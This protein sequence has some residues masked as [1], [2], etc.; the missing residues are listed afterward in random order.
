[1]STASLDDLQELERRYA[2]G[3]YARNP[4]QFVRGSGCR[5]WDSDGH[6]YLDFLAGISVLNVGH[7]HP[8]VVSA[9][10]EQAGRLTHATNLYYTAPALELSARLAESSL[11]GKVFLCNSGAEAN[12]A[13]IKLARRARPQGKLI[14]LEEAFHGRTYGALSATPQESKQAPFAPLVPGFE[15]VPKQATALAAAVDDQTAA[16]LLEPIQGETGIHVLSHEL[17]Q[18]ARAACDA[19]GAALIF[20]EIQTGMGRTGTLWAYEQCGVVPDALTSAKALGGGLPAGAL[21]TGPRLADVFQTGDHGS[22]FAGGPLVASAALVALEICS[23]PAL[24]EQVRTLGERLALG[25]EALPG[26]A[27]V[28]GRGLMVGADLGEGISAPELARRALL[29]QRLVINAT[30]PATVRFEPPLVVSGPE[31]DEALSRMGELLR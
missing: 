29:E 14:V 21:V 31:I 5:L 26:I 6:E 16:V 11:G 25:L 7:C 13:A 23:E 4:V 18:A 17:L 30:G 8:R 10:R 22:T 15:V 9:V 1:M 27:A 3:T 24:L 2:I 19:H 12:E 28:R 20:D